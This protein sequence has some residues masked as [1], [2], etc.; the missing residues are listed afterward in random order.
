LYAKTVSPDGTDG[1]VVS[2]SRDSAEIEFDA[3]EN[4]DTFPLLSTPVNLNV[5]GPVT[6]SG[7]EYVIP[8]LIVAME[9]KALKVLVVELYLL[10]QYS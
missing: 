1:G 5:N 8:P 7:A 4:A 10:E 2:I 3:S 6:P 9:P